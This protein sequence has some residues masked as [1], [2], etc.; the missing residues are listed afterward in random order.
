MRL[1]KEVALRATDEILRMLK[2]N[3]YGLPTRDLIGTPRFHGMNTL[4][5]RQI[6]RLLKQHPNIIQSFEG[7]GAYA[8][9]WWQFKP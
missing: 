6:H 9:S 2:A 7:G 8:S 1:T 5:S 3:P 4:T